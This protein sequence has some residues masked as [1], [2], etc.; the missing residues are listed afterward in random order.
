MLFYGSSE[1]NDTHQEYKI[2]T[3]LTYLDWSLVYLDDPTTKIIFPVL[4]TITHPIRP[5]EQ[6]ANIEV[7]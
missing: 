4:N 5:K 3:L 7:E 6:F 1:Q 2:A